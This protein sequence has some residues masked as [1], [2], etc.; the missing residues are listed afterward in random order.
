MTADYPRVNYVEDCRVWNTS[1]TMSG[2]IH[3]KRNRMLTPNKGVTKLDI[4]KVD[5]WTLDDVKRCFGD[6]PTVKEAMK[7]GFGVR[8]K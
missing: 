6:D 4:A 5:S 8:R 2:K 3:L 1:L 7:G